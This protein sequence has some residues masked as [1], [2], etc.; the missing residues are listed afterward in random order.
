V[1]PLQRIDRASRPL[2][3]PFLTMIISWPRCARPRRYKTFSSMI[4]VPTPARI[5]FSYIANKIASAE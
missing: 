5:R 4:G 3:T 1:H 2:A